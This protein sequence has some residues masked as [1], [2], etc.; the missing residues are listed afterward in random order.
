MDKPVKKLPYNYSNFVKLQL[1]VEEM[2]DL[3]IKM[4]ARQAVEEKPKKPRVKK[5]IAK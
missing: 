1:E 2:Q 4:M 5:D 3:L